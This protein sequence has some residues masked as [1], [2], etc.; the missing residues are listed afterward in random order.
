MILADQAASISLFP[1]AQLVLQGALSVLRRDESQ[2]CASHSPGPEQ[3]L[4]NRPAAGRVGVSH[5]EL[6][7]P[8][9]L[10]A[11]ALAALDWLGS[12]EAADVQAM[13]A[14]GLLAMAVLEDVR[15]RAGRWG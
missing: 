9:V 11:S 10:T 13:A 5:Q 7:S 3:Q 15:K 12:L 2:W 8:E 6:G 4:P 1:A 14:R